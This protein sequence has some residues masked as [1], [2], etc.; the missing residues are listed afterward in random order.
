MAP[1]KTLR[2][3]GGGDGVMT[4]AAETGREPELLAGADQQA[5]RGG[6]GGCERKVAAAA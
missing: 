3:Q 4:A 1:V 2:D 6:G 5:Q